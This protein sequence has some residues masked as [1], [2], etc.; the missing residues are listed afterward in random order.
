MNVIVTKVVA[1]N[2]VKIRMD[3]TAANV[4]VVISYIQMGKDV[5]VSPKY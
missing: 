4:T 5:L 3:R 1:A 2:F